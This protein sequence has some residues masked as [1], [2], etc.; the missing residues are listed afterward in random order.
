MKITQKSVN[1]LIECAKRKRITRK[2]LADGAGV[3][4]S[5]LSL[6][7]GGYNMMPVEVFKKIKTF[8]DNFQL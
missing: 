4:Y 1:E 3:K 8:I 5:T 2:E 7:I 6:Y